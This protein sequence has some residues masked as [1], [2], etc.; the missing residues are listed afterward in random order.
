MSR[1][2]CGDLLLQKGDDTAILADKSTP[3]VAL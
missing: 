3:I 2:M 1:L